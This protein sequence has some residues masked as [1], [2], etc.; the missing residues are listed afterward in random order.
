M[1]GFENILLGVRNTRK[2][3]K[4]TGPPDDKKRVAASGKCGSSEWR[5][6]GP[7]LT[8]GMT[9]RR[10]WLQGENSYRGGTPFRID[11]H[12]FC[13]SKKSQAQDDRKESAA[14]GKSGSSEWRTAGPS[15]TVGMTDRR[16]W[17]QGEN[18]Y[19]GGTP[20]R[21]D[22]HY[23]CASKKSQAQDDRKES[24]GER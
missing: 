4:V 8:V 10:G 17:L 3:E 14:N 15:P 13:A 11:S 5:T 16:G 18:G 12:Y 19:R 21:I 23:F 22:S 7:S 20:F 24:G 2:N 6:A 9:D 1:E